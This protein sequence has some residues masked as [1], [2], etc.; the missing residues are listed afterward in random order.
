MVIGGG[1]PACPPSPGCPAD[2]VAAPAAGARA[3]P[4]DDWPGPRPVSGDVENTSSAAAIAAE[5][6]GG[7]AVASGALSSAAVI[8]ASAQLSSAAACTARLDCA[9]A[10]AAASRTA[11]ATGSAAAAPQALQ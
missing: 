8:S 4:D 1:G 6:G 3:P 9:P 2:E 10:V 5:L 11:M 7:S